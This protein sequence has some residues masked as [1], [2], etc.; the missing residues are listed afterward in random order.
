VHIRDTATAASTGVVNFTHRSRR[1]AARALGRRPRGRFRT[2]AA[3]M[4][5]AVLESA[6]PPILVASHRRS[7]TH[8]TI[9]LLRRQF[10]ECDAW[11]WPGEGLDALYVNLDRLAVHKEPL[12][13]PRLASLLARSQHPLLKT[14]ALP[15]LG[16]LRDV[17]G[18][19]VDQLEGRAKIVYVVRYGPAVMV[20]AQRH[21][22]RLGQDAGRD[23]LDYM[24]LER[25]GQSR[26]AAWAAHVKRWLSRE[27]VFVV[28][29][30]EILWRGAETLAR[31]GD[32]LGLEPRWR[33][34]IQPPLI[35]PPWQRRLM[36]LS[37]RRPP[38]TALAPPTPPRPWR[39]LFGPEEM[40]FFDREAGSVMRK[41]GYPAHT[42]VWP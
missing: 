3:R 29:Y 42:N 27:G 5:A 4:S 12:T 19:W 31:L 41:L 33:R 24:R 30:E 36:R 8:L 38:T 15:D 34:P 32:F 17:Q 22:A 35:R 16:A 25:D 37:H 6:G 26:A 18:P 11:K 2:P 9:D 7:G 28:R 20:S 40:E 10:R 21:E 39:E 1:L 13:E 23:L 14:H